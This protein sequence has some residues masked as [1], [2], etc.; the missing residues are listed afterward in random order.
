M[1]NVYPQSVN[2]PDG[3]Y[4]WYFQPVYTTSPADKAYRANSL[5]SRYTLA[6]LMPA[7]FDYDAEYDG[8][9]FGD[10]GMTDAQ[11][12]AHIEWLMIKYTM[13][14]AIWIAENQDE[15]SML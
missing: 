11:M 6:R 10:T 8:V 2:T 9:E 14:A 4:F 15:E 1:I 5:R 12:A 7:D 3:D 13:N